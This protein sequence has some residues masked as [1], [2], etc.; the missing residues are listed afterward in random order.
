MVFVTLWIF[1][2]LLVVTLINIQAVKAAVM[3]MKGETDPVPSQ[4]KS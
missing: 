3:F 4:P 2:A 1:A